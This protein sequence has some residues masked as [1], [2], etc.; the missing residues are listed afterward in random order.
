[1][2]KKAKGKHAWVK[3]AALG[4]VAALVLAGG[5]YWFITRGGD[6]PTL[7][8]AFLTV[9]EPNQDTTIQT[10]N[11]IRGHAA[12]PGEVRVW[13]KGVN[14]AVPALREGSEWSYT[15]QGGLS[16]KETMVF[17][18][19]EA[20]R[21]SAEVERDYFFSS[22]G[23]EPA[24][25]AGEERASDHMGVF[26]T[27]FRPIE[28]V[29]RHV[30]AFVNEGV[31]RA[32]EIVTGDAGG[33]DLDGNGVPD[34]VQGSPIA[35]T[36]MMGIPYGWISIT[37]LGIVIVGA[38]VLIWRGQLFTQY[39]AK[40]LELR[41]K[42]RQVEAALSEKQLQA[43]KELQSK[44]LVVQGKLKGSMIKEGSKLRQALLQEQAALKAKQLDLESE[45]VRGILKVKGDQ[46]TGVIGLKK[47]QLEA[48]KSV[49][50]AKIRGAVELR[51]GAQAQ[52]EGGGWFKSFRKE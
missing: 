4:L 18:L 16:G 29:V 31:H 47:T 38:V 23:S 22:D 7:V 9:D 36:R 43:R 34:V 5:A 45:K 39:W 35:P 32:P 13:V 37:V 20:G 3:W 52:A 51:R 15:Y 14:F 21:W 25:G 6:E 19:Y 8:G 46:V 17:A 40:R 44:L 41:G 12:G 24:Q 30:V 2:A 50:E 28:N 1:M 48:Q 33:G 26:R 42:E 27:I 11:T 49:H 10:G